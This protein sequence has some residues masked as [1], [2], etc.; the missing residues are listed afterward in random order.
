MIDTTIGG[1]RLENEGTTQP[2]GTFTLLVNHN[3][4][5]ELSHRM[6]VI[7]PAISAL[8]RAHLPLLVEGI[9]TE[10]VVKLPAP[11]LLVGEVRSNTGLPVEN[12]AISVYSA[13]GEET[14]APRLIGVG[15]ST[16]HGEF[17]I[18]V[19]ATE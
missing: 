14:D 12:V 13:N 5:L 6:R 19:P 17:F 11:A 8:P 15:S 9:E 10:L 4:E 7:P 16:A 2:D 18:P 3:I 1:I